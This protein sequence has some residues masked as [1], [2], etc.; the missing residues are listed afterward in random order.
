MQEKRKQCP[1]FPF[2]AATNREKKTINFLNTQQKCF[3]KNRNSIREKKIVL[4]ADGFSV[5]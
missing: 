2:K 1:L 5:H 3:R 4:Q